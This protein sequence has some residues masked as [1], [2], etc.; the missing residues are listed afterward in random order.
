MRSIRDAVGEFMVAVGGQAVH[1]D[2]IW[3]SFRNQ[4]V[5]DLV[6][7]ED[8]FAFGSFFFLSHAD[9]GIRIDNIS[10]A[11]RFVRIPEEA[12]A[13]S[14]AAGDFQAVSTAAP[15]MSKFSGFAMLKFAP[16]LAL[17]CMRDTATL[18]PSPT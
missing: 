16:I 2:D 15:G 8:A 11:D 4:L 7:W 1:H 17:I 13:G 14:A 10:E 9:P 12:Q 18:L 3:I 6:G 5:I